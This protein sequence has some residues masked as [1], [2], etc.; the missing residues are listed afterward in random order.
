M[1]FW[2]ILIQMQKH[3]RDNKMMLPNVVKEREKWHKT[4]AEEGKEFQQLIMAQGS[5]KSLVKQEESKQD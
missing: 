1:C 5:L 4:L 3:D 2:S